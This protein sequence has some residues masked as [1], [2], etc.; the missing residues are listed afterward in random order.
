MCERGRKMKKII[1]HVA[2]NET[3]A[4]IVENEHLAEFYV[5]KDNDEQIVG[6]IYL[7]KVENVL[8]GMQAAFIDIGIEKNAFLYVDDAL[9]PEILNDKDREKPFKINEVLK[10]GQS[11]LVQVKKEAFGTKGP[12]VTTHI[13]IPGRYLVFMP[14]FQYVG[15]SKKIGDEEER[16]RLKEIGETIREESEGVIIRTVAEGIDQELLRRDLNFLRAI[17]NKTDQ[18]GKQKKGPALIYKDLELVYRLVRDLLSEDVKQFVIDH[19]FSYRKVKEMVEA[20]APEL[21]ERLY[22]YSEKEHIFDAF[23]VQAEI[24]K[25]LRRKVWLKSGGYIVFDQ[26]EALTVIDVNTG[27]YIGHSHLEDTVLKTNIEAAIEIAKQLRLR[28]IGGIIIIDFIDMKKEAH[29]EQI[30]SVLQTEMDK[31]RTK[32]NILGLTQLGLVEMT[33]KKA[34]QNLVSLLS[35]T[36]PICDGSGRVISEE[37][38]VNKIERDILSH[39]DRFSIKGIELEVNPFVAK[40]L[41]GDQQK[42]IRRIKEEVGKEIIIKENAMFHFHQYEMKYLS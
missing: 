20:A 7:G 17:W 13:S 22:F 30:L 10:E 15:V 6:N 31:D 28:D 4:A 35:R 26:T 37:E 40:V 19:G 2:P 24:D 27:K 32:S 5:E 39:K 14:G 29:R 33:R 21:L 8:P 42:N 1:V 12:R 23:H 16:L 36:C 38:M 41:I 11:I 18:Q 3:R 9:P 34:R 25:V